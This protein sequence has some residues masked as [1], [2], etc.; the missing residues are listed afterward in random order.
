MKSLT[1]LTLIAALGAL[2]VTAPAAHA[3]KK[4][5][6]KAKKENKAAK[7]APKGQFSKEFIAVYKPANDALE[8]AKDAQKAK[9]LVPGVFAAAKSDDEKLQAGRLAFLTGNATNDVALQKQGI[10]MALTSATLSPELR[11]I[12]MFQRGLI[13][14]NEKNFAG[15]QTDFLAA[16]NAGYRQNNIEFNL[17]NTYQQLKNLPE[18]LTW[19]QKA[20]DVAKAS[21]TKADKAIFVRGLSISGNMKDVGRVAHWG[22]QM[23]QAYPEPATYRDATVFLDRVAALDAQESLDLLRLARL[24]KGL[25]TENDY[26]NYL[27]AADARRFPAEAMSVIDEGR[28]L[29]II[30]PSNAFFTEQYATA[31]QSD[32]VLRTSWDIDEKSALANARGMQASLFGDTMLSFSEYARAQRVYEAA[33][34]KGNIIDKDNKNQVD[35][36][37]M[38]LA[39][40]KFMQGNLAGAKTDFAAVADPRR[41][42][43][44]DLWLVHIAQKGG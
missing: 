17:G 10:E 6:E 5:E 37:R 9:Q 30:Q 36:A 11:G 12:F 22:K 2:T 7:G 21:N 43:I 39:I 13:Q 41:K 23:V 32:A 3:Q 38:R 31:K 27:E 25:I 42:A 34:Q 1:K 28:S 40:S 44:A 4:K 16:Y 19:Y 26:R 15:A 20:V 14:S 8:T 33:L 35:R 24:N 29:K 18:A